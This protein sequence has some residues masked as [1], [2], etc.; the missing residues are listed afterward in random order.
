MCVCVCVCVCSVED[1]GIYPG[2][3]KSNSIK[4]VFAVIAQTL[5]YGYE[6]GVKWC[7]RK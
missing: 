2:R 4:L 6:G 5:V 7:Y 3:V 1:Y